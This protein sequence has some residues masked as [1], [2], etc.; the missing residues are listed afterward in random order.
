VHGCELWDLDIRSGSDLCIAW[1]KGLRRVWRFPQDTCYDLLCV[2]SDS[3][4]LQDEIARRLMIFNW[5]V[6]AFTIMNSS[7]GKT[8]GLCVLKYSVGEGDVC[9][10]TFSRAFLFGALF[11]VCL[12]RFLR[13]R[14]LRSG[15]YCST[16]GLAA[17]WFVQLIIIEV[18]IFFYY[19]LN[20]ALRV[21][22]MLHVISVF[23]L[24]H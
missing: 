3:I 13:G 8:V 11:M 4:S 24:F 16:W 2:I 23:S 5:W 20:C 22:L 12:G 21:W 6:Y 1:R 14:M 19:W 15:P 9:C 18:I 10:W 7:I 17:A